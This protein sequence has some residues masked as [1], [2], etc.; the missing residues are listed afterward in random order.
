MG[1]WATSLRHFEK[2]WIF[3]ENHRQMDLKLIVSGFFCS[4]FCRRFVLT[5]STSGRGVIYPRGTKVLDRR[6]FRINLFSFVISLLWLDKKMISCWLCPQFWFLL[7]LFRKTKTWVLCLC[8]NHNLQSAQSCFWE[9]QKLRPL[10]CLDYC[11]DIL[12]KQEK[13]EKQPR[14]FRRNLWLSMKADTLG[15]NWFSTES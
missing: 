5:P 7:S 15:D 1:F 2:N 14:I 9:R 8:H 13:S 6:A 10:A 3:Q 12:S 11:E 4:L